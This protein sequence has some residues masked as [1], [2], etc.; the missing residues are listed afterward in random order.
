MTYI[1]NENGEVV[2]TE[3]V[4]VG[5]RYK[6]IDG[7]LVRVGEG[8]RLPLNY[9]GSDSLGTHG[10]MSQADGKMYDS[11]SSYYRSIKDRGLEIIGNEPVK[12]ATPKQTPIDWENAVA[13]TLKKTP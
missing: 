12:R 2:E 13:E 11:K 7:K 8:K 1:L 5:G 6:F 4:F 3:E 10:I 9:G